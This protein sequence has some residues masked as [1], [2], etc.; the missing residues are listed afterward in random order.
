MSEDGEE[1]KTARDARDKDAKDAWAEKR[2]QQDKSYSCRGEKFDYDAEDVE[3]AVKVYEEMSDISG[4]A[5]GD[6]D[7]SSSSLAGLRGSKGR[8][9][10][11][12]SR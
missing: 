5:G 10:K 7:F 12:E 2:G 9:S 6:G 1:W 4:A 3:R 11:E 8:G